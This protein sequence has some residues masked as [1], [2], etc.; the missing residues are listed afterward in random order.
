MQNTS[1]RFS[2]PGSPLIE[3]A[4]NYFRGISFNQFQILVAVVCGVVLAK[5]LSTAHFLGWALIVLLFAGLL[6]MKRPNILMYTIMLFIPIQWITLLGERLRVISFLTLLAFFFFLLTALVNRRKLGDRIVWAYLAFIGICSLSLVNSID[7]GVSFRYLKFFIFSLLF[8]YSL[9]LSID[10]QTQVKI[11]LR[12]VFGWGITLSIMA[13]LQ[14]LVSTAFYPSHYIQL[15]GLEMVEF[16]EVAGINRASGTFENGPRFAMYLLLPLSFSLVAVF[17]RNEKGKLF[18]VA[19][20]S[21]FVLALIMSFTRAALLLSV[22]MLFLL[23][24][25]ERRSRNMIKSVVLTMLILSFI[26]VFLYLLLPD[27]IIEALAKRFEP[28]GSATY[29]DRFYF[30]WNALNAFLENP[31]LGLGIGTYS[32]HSWDLMQKYPVPWASLRWEPSSLSMPDL[33]PVHNA[34]GRI[35]AETGIFGLVSILCVLIFTIRN[36]FFV[37]K[38]TTKPWM[39]QVALSLTIYFIVMCIYWFAHE[40]IIEEPYISILP[41]AISII[42]VRLVRREKTAETEREL[43]QLKPAT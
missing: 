1:S 5:A 29:K 4:L 14:S 34:Y 6:L 24:A 10:N 20:L 3:S 27:Q 42:M 8:G 38:N 30:L 12:I 35:L 33:V 31:F 18:Q 28:T 22:V 32:L 21:L 19:C 36:L 43:V 2:F 17:S 23:F 37:L 25:I 26:G 16:Y 15:Y 7:I 9:I 11:I 39:H 13:L 41:V 40:Y